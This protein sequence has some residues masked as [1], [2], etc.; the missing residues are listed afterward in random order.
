MV[1][2]PSKERPGRWWLSLVLFAVIVLG[3]L[4]GAVWWL[5]GRTVWTDDRGVTVADSLARLRQVLW[6]NE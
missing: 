2:E 1:T 4:I 6:G 5:R 3:L